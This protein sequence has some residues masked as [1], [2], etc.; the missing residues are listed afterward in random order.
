MIAFRFEINFG[1]KHMK[2]IKE[3]KLYFLHYN[4]GGFEFRKIFGSSSHM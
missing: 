2:D 4:D 3:N 1:R